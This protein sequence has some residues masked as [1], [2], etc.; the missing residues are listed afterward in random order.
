VTTPRTLALTLLCLAALWPRVSAETIPPRGSI[1][2]R[3]RTVTYDADDVVKL[4]GYVGY[5]IHIEWAPGEE[6]V[7]LG[8]GDVGGFDVGTEGNHF[9]IKPKQEHVSTNVT[10]LTNRR[11]YHFDYTVT[12]PPA[13][14]TPASDVVYS[15]RFV[16]PQDDARRVAGD[17]ERRKVDARLAQAASRPRNTDYWYC[18][19]PSLQP[20]SAYDDG[21]QTRLKFP[22][23]ADFPAIFVKNDDNSE[24]L[25]NFNV[26]SDEV[27]IHRVARRFVLRRGQLVGCIVNQAFEGG[28]ER[29]KSNT[30][31]PGVQ[32]QTLGDAP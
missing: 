16:Y 5:Q 15:I 26:D 14:V 4:H 12:K 21:V 3:V 17:S 13:R 22:A 19:T 10:V 24:S 11:T 6:F 23:R 27:V 29:L 18:G 2:P 1:D 28:G 8:A 31:A 32:R 7:N 20:S 25:L 9:F 30:T